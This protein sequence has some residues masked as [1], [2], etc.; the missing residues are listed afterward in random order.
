MEPKLHKTPK[1]QEELIWKGRGRV[2]W[3]MLCINYKETFILTNEQ[4]AERVGTTSHVGLKPRLPAGQAL[5]ASQLKPF[6][7]STWVPSLQKARRKHSLS[8]PLKSL[9]SAEYWEETFPQYPCCYR[10]LHV[11]SSHQ[12]IDGYHPHELPGISLCQKLTIL[13]WCSTSPDPKNE[14]SLADMFWIC[15]LPHCGGCIL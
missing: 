10:V 4:N 2:K 8:Q 9:F 15:D 14:L 12:K 13:F 3:L 7:L 6:N 5:T 11:V 1:S